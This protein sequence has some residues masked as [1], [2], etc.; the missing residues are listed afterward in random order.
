MVEYYHIDA[1][2]DSEY[3]DRYSESSYEFFNL[4]DKEIEYSR[5]WGRNLIPCMQ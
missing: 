3:T 4:T 2:W 1:T 5:K